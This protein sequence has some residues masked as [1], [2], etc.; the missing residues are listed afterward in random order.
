MITIST[1]NIKDIIKY[2]EHSTLEMKACEQ[3]LPKDLW[4]TYSAFANTHGGV[5][6][7]G[8]TEHKNLPKES[9]FEITGVA[10]SYKVTTDLFNILRNPEKVSCN[11]LVDS[12]VRE[13]EVDGKIVLCI[14]V[15]EADY[16]RKP[17]YI[18]NNF[19]D[20]TYIRTH[21][22]DR[23]A[24]KE[25]LA[26][27][28]RNSSDD[29]D[30]IIIENYGMDDI[31]F[32][33]LKSYR[34]RFNI[35]HDKHV[36]AG[37]D[38]KEFLHQMGGYA[39]DRRKKIEGLTM[40]GLMMFGK[41]ISI[42]EVYPQFRPDYLDRIGLESGSSEKWND[43]LTDDGS[44]EHNMFNF[45]TLVL[46][47]LLLTLPNPGRLIG[48]ERADGSEVQDAVMEGVVNSVIHCDFAANGVL[49]IERRSDRIIMRNPGNLRV[50][51]EKIYEGDFTHARNQAMQR[52]LRMV[53][54]GDN[55]GSGF[56]KILEA[57]RKES[58]ITP[59]LHEEDEVHEVWLTLRMVSLLD[60]AVIE[61]LK[62][63]YGN[64][65]DSLTS[66]E[67]ETLSLIVGT[68]ANTNAQ[69]Q[70]LTDKNSWILNRILS[71]LVDKGMLIS[72]P[73]GRWT[74]YEPN[75]DYQKKT[76]GQSKDKETNKETNSQINSQ[77]NSQINQDANPLDI[78]DK[79][80][81][82]QINS[83]INSQIRTRIEN[84]ANLSDEEKKILIAMCLNPTMAM[85]D[86]AD[87]IGMNV[88]AVRY[89][90][91]KMKHYVNTQRVGSNKAGRWGIQF[92]EDGTGNTSPA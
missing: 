8:I 27:L 3:K 43:R 44:W 17:I 37:L 33:T 42:R 50:G 35:R 69:L 82:S 76:E 6:L 90:R 12:D 79:S 59:D 64:D 74:T 77:K 53:G 34:K 47:K 46:R 84:D 71:S 70:R 54:Y 72:T 13:V 48:G 4:E 29:L 31:D 23:H 21:E 14:Y 55:I 15:P 87:K 30:S 75:P 56:Q 80:T 68:D 5:I 22:G 9:R 36:Y 89:Q 62:T 83:Q 18:N 63:L 7:L 61:S 66:E 2:G 67:K 20:G 40:A 19:R 10:D 49:R 58:W 24:N 26:M 25:E 81:D 11:I 45:V 16:H 57:W 86:L 78:N 32:E 91:E 52:M 1:E 65:F 41:G 85:K 88:S 60:P 73:K 51:R 38:D 92:I 28:T 39:F